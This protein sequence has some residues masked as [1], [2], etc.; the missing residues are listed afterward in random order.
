MSYDSIKVVGVRTGVVMTPDRI[1]DTVAFDLSDVDLRGYAIVSATLHLRPLSPLST[2]VLTDPSAQAKYGGAICHRTERAA[3]IPLTSEAVR[4]LRGARG[5][6]FSIST[7][8]RDDDGAAQRLPS[9][10]MHVLALSL[11]RA[12]GGDLASEPRAAA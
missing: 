3:H 9:I 7:L 2:I 1:L 4:D 8:V 11:A 10:G 6:F 12:N 5:S